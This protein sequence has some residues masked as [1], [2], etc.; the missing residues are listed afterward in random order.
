MRKH[1]IHK[2]ADGHATADIIFVDDDV[3]YRLSSYGVPE[4]GVCYSLLDLAKGV[5]EKLKN[6]DTLLSDEAMQEFKEDSSELLVQMLKM[7]E[8]I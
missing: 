1:D 2:D 8:D 7:L 4:E 6:K 5:L 3:T